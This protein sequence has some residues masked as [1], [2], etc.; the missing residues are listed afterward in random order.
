MARNCVQVS[1]SSLAAIALGSAALVATL[2]RSV[3]RAAGQSCGTPAELSAV[4]E[5]EEGSL[6]QMD[7]D[8]LVATGPRHVGTDNNSASIVEDVS[9]P[10]AAS[11]LGVAA[12]NSGVQQEKYASS[13]RFLAAERVKSPANVS[14]SW[15]PT[16]HLVLLVLLCVAAFAIAGLQKNREVLREQ[17][18]GYGSTHSAGSGINLCK[19]RPAIQDD[20][21]SV[22]MVR[23]P[24][25]RLPHCGTS[26]VVPL[27]CI[28]NSGGTKELS[29]DITAGSAIWPFHA[30]L[31]RSDDHGPW[32][33]LDLTVD[34][35]AATGMPPLFSCK[36]TNVAA[37]Q[38]RGAICGVSLPQQK[39]FG[40][41]LKLCDGSGRV[42]GT[43]EIQKDGC[44]QLLRAGQPSWE[45]ELRPD[46][47]CWLVIR[48]N[49][50]ELA[51]TMCQR[52]GGKEF[53]Q[54]DVQPDPESP[55][56][57][58][59]LFCTLAMLVLRY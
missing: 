3:E 14:D 44:C 20:K 19:F 57:A 49:L 46:E 25:P 31:R 37:S 8:A 41:W 26:F 30:H 56:S 38:K 24:Q 21:A 54:V 9:E 53:L 16:V 27:A 15:I 2:P 34:I 33:D 51:I 18:S 7:N 12:N 40:E 32:T 50:Q 43:F 11:H 4:E 59:L 48:K 29:F 1:I 10:P 28:A 23:P 52:V 42:V 17:I 13:A 6:F 45:M 22:Q 58:L 55:D 47:D 39:D 5:Q 36:Q 35:I